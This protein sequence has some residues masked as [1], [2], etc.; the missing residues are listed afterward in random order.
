MKI[1]QIRLKASDAQ[2]IKFIKAYDRMRNLIIEL[3]N[4]EIPSSVI[5]EINTEIKVINTFSGTDGKKI[6]LIKKGYARVLKLIEDEQQLV[7]KNHYRNYWMTM[8]IAFGVPLGTVFS[9]STGNYGLIGVGIPI[10]MAIGV[11]YGTKLDKKAEKEGRQL[12]LLADS[13]AF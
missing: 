6:K 13:E 7:A 10:G 1:E 8:G 5:T 12:N 2:N 11:A 4:R 3:N 9:S